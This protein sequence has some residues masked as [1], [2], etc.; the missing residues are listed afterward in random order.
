M[1]KNVRV[2]TCE[3]ERK[4]FV[5]KLLNN[6]T[7]EEVNDLLNGEYARNSLLAMRKD[8][9]LFNEFCSQKGVNS[10]PAAS[11]AVR[12]FLEKESKQ[13]KYSTIKRYSVTLG[14]F[15]KTLN[16][17]DPTSNISVRNL[18][19][20]LRIDKKSDAKSTTSFNRQHLETLTNLLTP[21]KHVR[22]VR[23]LAIYH[24]M[25][26]CMLKRS[27]LRDLE[28]KSVCLNDGV[29]SIWIS[30]EEYRLSDEACEILNRWLTVRG[31][32]NGALFNAI[33][34]HGN[35]SDEALND[36]S[37]YRILRSASDKLK[38]GV[39]FSGL[40]LR[41]GAANELASQGMKV[42]DIQRFGRWK[43]AAMPYQYIG[44]QSQAA[45]ERMVY[46]SFKPWD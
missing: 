29:V 16:L 18:L 15:H 8:W 19:A 1:R 34:K 38:L 14:L 45:L 46:K 21:S 3:G 43:S 26:E 9:N 39:K 11:T 17:P 13:R 10:L 23:N 37:I 24:L 41:V 44:N 12:L 5:N 40:S 6:I 36:S 4:Q 25:F 7:I 2:V 32:H 28:L 33:D 20:S 30:T 27:E 31:S 42:K 35:I 22:D